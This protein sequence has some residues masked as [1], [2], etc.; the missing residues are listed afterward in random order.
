MAIRPAGSKFKI[1]DH[2]RNIGALSGIWPEEYT[3]VYERMSVHDKMTMWW[4]KKGQQPMY[5]VILAGRAGRVTALLSQEVIE[6][7]RFEPW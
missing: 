3:R 4:K 7:C 5:G 6:G 1:N 2:L